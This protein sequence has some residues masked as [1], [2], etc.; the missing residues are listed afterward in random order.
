MREPI[1]VGPGQ[2]TRALIHDPQS[3]FEADL[4]ADIDQVAQVPPL[5]EIHHDVILTGLGILV[6]SENRDDV[7]VAHTQPEPAFPHEQV[8]LLLVE[9]P[10][11][12]QDLD[13]KQ[14]V[15]C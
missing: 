6:D 8:H 13:Q 12:A 7:G 9:R 14:R 5:H 4:F 1:H 3:F 10:L 15:P 11:V 2:S